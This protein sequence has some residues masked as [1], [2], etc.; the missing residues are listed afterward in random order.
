MPTDIYFTS[1]LSFS[2]FVSYPRSSLNGTQPHARK[3]VRFENACPKSRVSSSPTNRGPK[4]VFSGWLRNLTAN[5]TAYIFGMKH[6]IDNRSSALT[7]TRGLLRRPKMSW[8]LVHKPLQTRPPFLP[9]LCEFRNPLYCQA[10]QTE[11][12]KQNSTTLC[13]TA[14]RKSR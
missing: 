11:I 14:D 12:S 4:T 9:N 8:S 1:F 6:D 13:Q 5:L 2:F 3:W 7:I 10:S